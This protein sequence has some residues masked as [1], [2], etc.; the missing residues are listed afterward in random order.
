MQLPLGL[1]LRFL[2]LHYWIRRMRGADPHQY[3]CER[4][5]GAQRSEVP[6]F[7]P[8]FLGPGIK[9]PRGRMAESLGPTRP[10]RE[11]RYRPDRPCRLLVHDA[12]DTDGTGR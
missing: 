4:H 8:P 9:S 5:T 11:R 1:E 7:L 3:P 12:D 2:T 10:A 6:H